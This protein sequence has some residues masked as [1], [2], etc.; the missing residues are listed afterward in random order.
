M[1]RSDIEEH[2]NRKQEFRREEPAHYFLIHDSHQFASM[3]E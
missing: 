3:T 1:T 2:R